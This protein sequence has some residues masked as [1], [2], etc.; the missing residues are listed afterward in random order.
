MDTHAHDLVRRPD[1]GVIFDDGPLRQQSDLDRVYSVLCS[2]HALYRLRT[3]ASA[4]NPH[5]TA[6]MSSGGAY[7]D[8]SRTRHPFD[9]EFT[10]LRD[11]ELRRGL[12]VLGEREAELTAGRRGDL[13]CADEAAEECRHGEGEKAQ[14]AKGRRDGGK[15]SVRLRWWWVRL[16]L[17]K[18]HTACVT[19]PASALSVATTWV[20]NLI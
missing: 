6:A 18:P 7:L 19:K 8:A 4:G 2:E 1:G 12:L 11:P 14:A 5:A 10:R 9:S 17:Q 3:H 15:S 16:K 13:V 20:C